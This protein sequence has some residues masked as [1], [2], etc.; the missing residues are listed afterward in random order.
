[1]RV[2][3]IADVIVAAGVAA[4]VLPLW[5]LPRRAAGWI[6]RRYGDIGYAAYGLGR[7]TGAINL[8]RACGPAMTRA[9]ARRMTRLVFESM[10]QAVAEGVWCLRPGGAAAFVR[11]G[12]VTEE[13]P[14]LTRQALADSRQ[15]ILVTA[16][17]GSWDLAIIWARMAHGRGAVVQRALDNRVLQAAL[18][19]ARAPLGD[20][21]PKRGAA[22]ESLRRL[23]QGQS[24]AMIVDENAGPRGC[25][26]PFF[27]RQ[28]SA[29]RTPALL[30]MQTGSPIVMAV[31][32]R[33][34][35]GR[36]LY[37]SAWFEPADP[38]AVWTVDSL[39]AALM[40]QLERWVR[41]DPDQWRW[42]H[43]RWK[44]RPD[45]TEERYDRATV[46]SC[47]SEHAS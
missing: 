37:R 36:Y 19:R 7:R 9:R 31:M 40:A 4:V 30:A 21:I 38:S 23:R 46:R 8:R 15:K 45:G 24:V 43:W 16:H 33:R 42:I 1:M 6:G 26:V 14:D 20:T 5:V 39:T 10:T 2:K 25:F 35:G 11:A 47:F 28:A 44:A 32:V 12:C 22:G 18:E 17:L 34:P 29:H 41:D 13:R 3:W 27:G